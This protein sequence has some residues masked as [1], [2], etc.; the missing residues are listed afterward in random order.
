MNKV[1]LCGGFNDNSA[2]TDETFLYDVDLDQWSPLTSIAQGKILKLWIADK[3]SN[4]HALLWYSTEKHIGNSLK[5][6]FLVGGKGLR[7]GL[8]VI[9][10]PVTNLPCKGRDTICRVLSFDHNT[11]VLNY[12][13]LEIIIT[14]S[15]NPVSFVL[16]SFKLFLIHRSIKQQ[17]YYFRMTVD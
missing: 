2:S 13:R 7:A 4:A 16:R 12:V 14:R 11:D 1:I 8:G 15:F 5:G 17:N 3:G 6:R 10:G 9:W